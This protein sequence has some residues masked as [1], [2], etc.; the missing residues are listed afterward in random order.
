MT[1]AQFSEYHS[2]EI[3]NARE[4]AGAAVTLFEVRFGWRQMVL[5][6]FSLKCNCGM[7]SSVLGILFVVFLIS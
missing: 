2:V 3:S 5:T 7:L 4:T 1:S 6:S